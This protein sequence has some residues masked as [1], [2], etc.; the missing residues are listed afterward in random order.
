MNGAGAWPGYMVNQDYVEGGKNYAND[1]PE[2][3]TE[4]RTLLRDK[5]FRDALSIGFDRARVI[6]VAWGGIAEAK[7]MTLSP[8]SWHFTVP[9]GDEVYKRWSE[10][11]IGFDVDAANAL[12]DEIG[13]EKGADGFRQLPSGEPFILTLDISDW[14]GSLKVQVDA[15]EEMKKQWGEN[16]GLNIEIKN[17]QGQ[18]D[19]DTRTN[20]GYYMLRGAH[21]SEIDI[22]T[23][24]DWLFPIVN[25]YM[26]PLE[27]RWF[28]KGGDQCTEEPVEGGTQYPCGLAPEAG[29]PAAQLQDLYNKARNTGTEMGRHEVVWEAIDVVINE[30]PFIISVAG[31]Q[32]M[33]III[34]NHMRN[35]MDFGVVGPWAPSTP[36][37]QIAAQWWIEQ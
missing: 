33:P 29:S 4:I 34:K 37:N 36:G 25:R 32:P 22:L 35:I 26:F 16:L 14:G 12:L 1:T 21:I 30:G 15:A 23:Y 24:P 11:G 6:D 18:P 3:A 20:E 8:Q 5:R 2:K 13:M 10:A 27:G 17:L 9:G 28:A 31:D 19:L 7:A